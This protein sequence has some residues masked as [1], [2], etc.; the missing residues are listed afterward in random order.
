MIIYSVIMYAVGI[1]MVIIG[2][3]VYK[4]KTEL[5]HSY[6]QRKVKDKKAYAKA[7]GKVLLGISLPL[8]VSGT[9]G[10]FTASAL[11]TVILLVGLAVALVP[12]FLVQNK[13]NGGLF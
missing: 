1:L 6:H 5:I 3:L 2:I 11:P 13:Y 9:V 7:M 12:L 10:L 4:G 8:F